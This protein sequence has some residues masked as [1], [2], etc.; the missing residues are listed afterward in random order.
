MEYKCEVLISP[1][2]ERV[3]AS[4]VNFKT[5]WAKMLM[6]ADKTQDVERTFKVRGAMIGVEGGSGIVVLGEGIILPV[7]LEY[8]KLDTTQSREE[9]NG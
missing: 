9:G 7:P 1:E 6:S 2:L 8:I 4:K 3:K 5:E